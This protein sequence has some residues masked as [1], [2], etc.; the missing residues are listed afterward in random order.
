MNERY[1]SI[2]V[3]T[4]IM[5]ILSGCAS[6]NNANQRSAY[7]WSTV[8]DIDSTKAAFINE[9]RITRLYVRYFDVVHNKAGSSPNATI[10]FGNLP[11]EDIEI[12]PTVFI[13]NECM[14][15]VG[16]SKAKTNYP[17][18]INQL[19]ENILNRV[20]QMNSTNDI[21][22]VRE[23]QIDCDW[24]L[25]TRKNFFNFMTILRRLTS[26]RNMKLSA[27]I[28]LHQ[29]SQNAP[30]CDRGVLMMYN[31]GNVSDFNNKKPILDMA[32][33]APYMKY[34]K[35]YKL[36]LSAAYPLF[37]WKVIY[38]NKQL[39]GIQHYD[40]EY[41]TLPT[42]SIR[43]YQPT[44]NDIISAKQSIEE[45]CSNVNNEIILYDLNNFNIQRFK[46]TD[47]ETI[48]DH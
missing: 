10:R 44:M 23:I 46:T 34:L 6:N 45:L 22:N 27:T 4:I 37:S 18:D 19:A 36:S 25:G 20:I 8:L 13:T 40:G 24:T 14:A 30:P 38:R 15:E 3:W 47:Y 48:L 16:K 26:E 33:A 17:Q 31:T 43:I 32:D 39:V 42:D 35:T 41:P 28:R 5:A 11:K 29:L 1:L 7:Y 21:Y 12:I 9:H 2:S